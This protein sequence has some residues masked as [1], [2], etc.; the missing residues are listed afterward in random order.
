MRIPRCHEPQ[1]MNPGDTLLLSDN[2]V[3]HLA[4]TLRMRAG[5]QVMLFNGDGSECLATATEVDKRSLQVRIESQERP[6]RDSPLQIH[7]GQTLSRGERMD[8]AVQK[9]T[10]LG[11]ARMTPLFSERCEVK[12]NSERQDKRLR[13][14]QQ[15]AISACEQSLRCTLPQLDAPEPLE[16]W[17]G[18]VEAD[19]KLVLHHHSA[20]PL[21]DLPRPS[22]IALLIG[23]E[24][25][26]TEAEVQLAI[27]AGFQPV[28]L[29]PRVLR[30]E[31]APVVAQAIL[32]SYWGDLSA[33]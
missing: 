26:L 21:G 29:G 32:Q 16:H 6:G 1:P 7:I 11:M 9:A 33:G 18:S 2:N 15:V 31:T 30:T 10:E 17:V 4:R 22:S 5:D 8:Y 27:A 28:A 19:L 20:R 13:H 14:W 24:G 23:P 12:L 3:Q 25:G